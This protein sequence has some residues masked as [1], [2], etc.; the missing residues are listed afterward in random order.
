MATVNLWP[1]EITADNGLKGPV[2]VLKEQAA[3]LG[4]KT[5]NLVE[6]EVESGSNDNSGNFVDRFVIYSSLINYRYDLFYIEYP[7][8]FYPAVVVWD[9]FNVRTKVSETLT[10][11][12]VNTQQ[13]LESTLQEIFSH[14]KT[15]RIIQTLMSR[16]RA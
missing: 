11:R 8:G 1:A 6:A 7:F 9:G 16:A 15:V 13:E 2:V 14:E 3:L 4:E 5:K 10:G 12:K